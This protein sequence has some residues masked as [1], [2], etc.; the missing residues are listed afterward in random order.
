MRPAVFALANPL[1]GFVV[2]GLGD[3]RSASRCLACV[4]RPA[5]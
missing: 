1:P 3:L 4:D 5:G 2:G